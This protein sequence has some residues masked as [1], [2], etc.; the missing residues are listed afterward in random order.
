MKIV[1]DTNV[2][3]ISVSDR[4]PVHWV[5]KRFLDGEYTLCVTSDILLEY[6]EILTRHMGAAVSD[7]VLQA[8]E[9]AVNTEWV[10]KFFHW[11]LIIADPDDNKFV[12]CAIACQA[13]FIVTEDKHFQVL[14]QVDF[15]K[16]EVV[17]VEQ[18]KAEIGQIS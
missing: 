1:L 12:D 2:L 17:S 7:F 18:F 9:N 6:E 5:F 14:K 16:V 15:P 4:S 10:T 13:K 8:I 11:N 3:L